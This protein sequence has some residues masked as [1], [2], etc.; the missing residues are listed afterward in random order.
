[1][2]ARRSEASARAEDP[3]SVI[4]DRAEPGSDRRAGLW[5]AE[6]LVVEFC[7]IEI[8]LC[9][10]GAWADLAARGLEA[11]P[12]MDPGFCLSAA[13]H[14]AAGAVTFLMVWEPGGAARRLL[15]VCPIARAGAS[16]WPIASVW[17]HDLSGLGAPLLCRAHAAPAMEALLA[18][19]RRRWPRR[20]GL[21]VTALDRDGPTARLLEALSED[22]R[23]E[24]RWLDPRARA[25][26]AGLEGAPAGL[27]ALSARRAKELQRQR[28]RLA[29]RGALRYDSASDPSAIDKALDGFLALEAS[30]WKGRA[31]TALG[32]SGATSAFVREMARRMAAQ[33]RCRIDA[34]LLDGAPVAMGI[35]LSSRDREFFWKTA[36]AETHAVLSPGVQFVLDLTA[37]QRGRDGL[38]LT[39]SCAVPDHPMIDRLWPERLT[40]AD[41]MIGIRSGSGFAFRLSLGLE[42]LR[43]EGRAVLKRLYRR[44]RGR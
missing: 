23:R 39:D 9:H 10:A 44:V 20:T 18:W 27:S 28:R 4:P 13:R 40:I 30:G 17:F 33:G 24:I 42:R 6:D 11:N 12:F 2:A 7:D 31:G 34:L 38:V 22:T 25:A 19:M 43:R 21:L 32:R 36:F 14:L 16:A 1:M 35:L 41:A 26:L 5:S 37:R 15:A 3:A 29:E 8:A